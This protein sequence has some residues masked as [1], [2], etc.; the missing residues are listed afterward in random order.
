M[1]CTEHPLQKIFKEQCLQSE[2]SPATVQDKLLQNILP[3][4]NNWLKNKFNFPLK[5][6][7]FL[8]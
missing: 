5:L 7:Y 1:D 8:I 4:Y 2:A 3:G 6:K